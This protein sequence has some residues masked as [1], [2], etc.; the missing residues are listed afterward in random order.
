MDEYHDEV[1]IPPSD[2]A[3][4]P[5]PPRRPPGDRNAR[6]TPEDKVFFIHYLRWA[7]H[8][9]PT[10]TRSELYEGLAEEVSV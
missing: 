1:L 4:K 9:D 6:F 3:V 10:L 2:P 7:L 8:S 5:A